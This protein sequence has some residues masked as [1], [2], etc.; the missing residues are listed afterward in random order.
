LPF[1]LQ[2]FWLQEEKRVPL[3]RIPNVAIGKLGNRSVSRL[4]FPCL[5]GTP[6]L[7]LSQ[8][9]LSKLYNL[10]IY[11]ALRAAVPTH[12]G[13]IP[14]TYNHAYA[15]SKGKK[16][17]MHFSTK[18][19][20]PDNI[21]T[22]EEVLFE[23]LD[24]IPEFRN[25][26]LMHEIRGSK[27]WAPHPPGDAEKREDA[28]EIVFR[29]IDKTHPQWRDD[30]WFIDV[31]LE[32]SSINSVNLW[33]VEN[34]AHVLSWSLGI[35]IHHAATLQSGSRFCYDH[36]V[37]LELLGGYRLVMDT[38]TSPVGAV[39]LQAY[40]TEKEIHYQLHND[41]LFRKRDATDLLPN[42]L[43]K[44]QE[45]VVKISDIFASCETGQEFDSGVQRARQSAEDSS[46]GAV[47]S[48]DDIEVLWAQE[49]AARLEVRVPLRSALHVLHELPDGLMRR[50]ALSV[51]AQTWW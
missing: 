39:Y 23:Q 20:G 38:T 49:G 35:P 44:L 31:A 11:P 43:K 3:H 27:T 24:H 41:G 50:T 22:F 48:D 29:D 5:Y 30:D 46:A 47:G 16:S 36:A 13:H 18:S 21:L 37:Q 10:A 33:L 51:P 8:E 7:R 25:A 15:Q 1:F 4:M 2:K 17:G 19:V 28:L 45:D 12:S 40:A 26:F 14:T 6:E 9:Q 32:V 34:A 42:K